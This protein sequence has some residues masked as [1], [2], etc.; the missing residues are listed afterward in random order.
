VSQPTVTRRRAYLEKNF[1]DGYTVIPKW[2]KVGF[3]IVAFTFVKHNV[4]YEKPEISQ[5]IY[6]NLREWMSKQPNA[7][8]AIGGQGMGWDGV[9]V[10]FHKHYSEYVE[11]LKKH[12]ST[13]GFSEKLLDTQSFIAVLDPANIKKTLHFKY[14]AEII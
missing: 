4:K 12:N 8:F 14:L 7:V 2:E 1:I 10:S 3:E 6:K 11:F 9:I 13:K 5:E